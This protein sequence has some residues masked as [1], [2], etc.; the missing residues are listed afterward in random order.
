MKKL[1]VLFI[2]LVFVLAIAGCT[3]N[4][5]QPVT[6][7]ESLAG[8]MV[9]EDNTLYLTE[10]E[11]IMSEDKERIIE[12][13]LTVQDMPNGYYIRNLDKEKES[14]VLTEETTYTFVDFNLLF[15]EGTDGDRLY[16][17][18]EKEEFIQ[19]LN[20]SYSDSP[21]AQNVPF[22]IQIR[23]GKVTNVTEKFEFTI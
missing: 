3:K 18:M 1:M 13:G 16:T 17:T 2:A 7:S 9:I 12:F 22:F 8:Y 5:E 20:T 11:V 23:D 21:P 19:H 4:G 6:E 14:Y 15:V 10:V